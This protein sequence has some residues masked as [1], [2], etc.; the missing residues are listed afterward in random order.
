MTPSE[1]E[2]I[3]AAFAAWAD[4]NM[5]PDNMPDAAI[6]LFFFSAGWKERERLAAQGLTIVDAPI[7]SVTRRPGETGGNLGDTSEKP[8]S[9]GI[10]LL[11]DAD[12]V[13]AVADAANAAEM[14]RAAG[15]LHPADVIEQQAACLAAAETLIGEWAELENHPGRED[16]VGDYDDQLNLLLVR[17][18]AYLTRA[19]RSS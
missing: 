6:D 15:F 13:E 10:P 12:R 5:T 3:A 9:G 8:H 1:D 2:R 16:R 4:E 17:R 19:E 11:L 14:I 18:D 7:S